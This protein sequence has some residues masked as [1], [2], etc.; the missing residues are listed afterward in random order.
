MAHLADRR[1]IVVPTALA[2]AAVLIALAV[3][4]W[5]RSAAHA[6]AGGDPG[7][8]LMAQIA[9]VVRVVPGFEHGHIRWI[10]FPCDSC[11]FPVTYAIKVEPRWDSCDGM[12]GTFGWDPVVIQVGFRWTGSSHALVDLLNERLGARGWARGAAPPWGTMR[13]P[14]GSARMDTPRR[15]SSR[16]ALPFLRRIINGWP[17]LR[18]SHKANWS[19]AA[20]A[21]GERIQFMRLLA[22]AS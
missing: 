21:H 8:R 16:S 15:R 7:G 10:V 2:A 11:Q 17:S 19:K 4:A 5:P 13:T 18:R 1:K 14:S 20:D 3:A 9:P 22:A 6:H 12:A